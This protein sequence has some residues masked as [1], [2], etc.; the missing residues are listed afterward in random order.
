MK[1]AFYFALF[2]L[3]SQAHTN[4]VYLCQSADG[5][6]VYQQHSRGKNCQAVQ[7]KTTFSSIASGVNTASSHTVSAQN[8]TP[9]AKSNS[10]TEANKQA[11]NE[12]AL[13]VAQQ[14]LAAAQQALAEGKAIRYGNERNYARYLERIQGL[15]QAVQAAEQEVQRLSKP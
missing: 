14:K 15:E 6:S 3:A 2:T 4:G 13:A 11:E 10:Q 5:K 9:T 12:H 1:T 8:P 7:L